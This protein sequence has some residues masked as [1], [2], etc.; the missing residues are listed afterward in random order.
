MRVLSIHTVMSSHGASLLGRKPSA[1]SSYSGRAHT[2][3][4]IDPDAVFARCVQH[5]PTN[6]PR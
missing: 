3:D 2:L 1:P 4:G 5:G 6:Y